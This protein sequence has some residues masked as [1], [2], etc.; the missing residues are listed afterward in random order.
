L[1]NNFIFLILCSS[2]NEVD[3]IYFNRGPRVELFTLDPQN[4]FTICVVDIINHLATVTL[5]IAVILD[6]EIEEI[7]KALKASDL[8]DKVIKEQYF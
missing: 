7:E 4:P 3:W 2:F 8:K 5:N 6:A 1:H